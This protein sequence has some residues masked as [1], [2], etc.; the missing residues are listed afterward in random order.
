MLALDCMLYFAN[1]HAD[2]YTK[3][4]IENSCR[5]DEHECPF[6]QTSIELV[7]LLCDVFRI[8]EPPNEQGENYVRMF[9]S[10]DHPFEEIFSVSINLVNKTWREMK[11]TVEDFVKVFSVV[12]E[13][14]TRALQSKPND[15]EHFRIVLKTLSYNEIIKIWQQERNTREEWESHAKPIIELKE[16]ITPEILEL[17]QQR[18]LNFLCEGTRFIK[19]NNR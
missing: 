12:R 17:I 14:I 9:F 7:K 19:Y 18:R 3:I 13:Q 1:H 10:H 2:Q 8:G 15:L 6:G 5:A 4:V 11:A 16:Q